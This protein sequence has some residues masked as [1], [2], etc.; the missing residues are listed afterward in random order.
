[1]QITPFL[2]KIGSF[3]NQYLI[4]DGHELTLIDTGMHNNGNNILL[5]ISKIGFSSEN[6]K[7]IL[8]THSDSDHY[9]S[10]AFL[11]NKTGAQIWTS[12]I[13]ADAMKNGSSSR[14]IKPKGIGVIFF[15]LLMSFLTSPPVEVDRIL[16]NGELLPILS[17]IQVISSPGH[18]PGHIS[19]YLPKE[20]ILIAGDAINTKKGVP[21]PTTDGTTGDIE[22][23]C[24]SF[25]K[26]MQ[27]NPKVIACGHTYLDLRK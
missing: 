9:G 16:I 3:V 12:Q 19:F 15:P 5:Y 26:L 24:V 10:A 6:L 2:H 14:E 18:T 23:A 11:K 13:E 27:F 1:M 7:R 4:I 20:N 21:V 17:G 22:L 25:T 8:I